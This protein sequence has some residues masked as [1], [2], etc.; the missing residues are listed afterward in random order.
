MAGLHGR[1]QLAKE[2]HGWAVL[3]CT[4]PTA[5]VQA[6]LEAFADQA[7]IEL[8]YH[9]QKEV[10]GAASIRC[11]TPGPTSASFISTCG[12]T[13]SSNCWPGVCLKSNSA[14]AATRRGTTATGPP[15]RA[16]RRHA[17]REQFPQNQFNALARCRSVSRK[18]LELSRCLAPLA[19]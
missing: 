3:F 10:W 1:N 9:D 12:C 14:T 19:A 7:T 17:L 16:S 6:I 2:E 15:S 18:I 4:E 8:N 5:S 13:R 11:A